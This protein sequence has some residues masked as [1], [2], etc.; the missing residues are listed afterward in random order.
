MPPGQHEIEVV[1]REHFRIVA[2]GEPD[3]MNDNV[4]GRGGRGA[5]C[6]PNPARAVSMRSAL[7]DLR[8]LLGADSGASS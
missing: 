2:D 1:I 5:W 8:R 6:R 7:R 3:A 4:H